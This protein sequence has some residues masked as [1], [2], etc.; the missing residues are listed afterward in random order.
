M[1]SGGI[2]A[3]AH[4]QPLHARQ[5][6]C[7]LC[8]SFSKTSRTASFCVSA[9]LRAIS[10]RIAPTYRFA[11]FLGFCLTRTANARN[12][13]LSISGSYFM[14]APALWAGMFFYAREFVISL[15]YK[16]NIC[17]RTNFHHTFGVRARA[18]P[19]L[20][21]AQELRRYSVGAA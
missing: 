1:R 12:S 4:L 18:T 7:N 5:N 9:R 3:E 20:H 16:K 15:K 13:R 2:H 21:I 11:H 19:I 14:R 6:N 10:S 17:L 8:A